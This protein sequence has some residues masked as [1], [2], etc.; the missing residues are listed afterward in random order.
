[1]R[2]TAQR[3]ACT[4]RPLDTVSGYSGSFTVCQVSVVGLPG[5]LNDVHG[6]AVASSRPL[7]AANAV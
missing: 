1:M 6:A 5:H 3:L 2:L 7:I 4:T